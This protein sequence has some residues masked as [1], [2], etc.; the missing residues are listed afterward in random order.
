MVT[1]PTSISDPIAEVAAKAHLS[2]LK[3][4]SEK[5]LWVGAFLGGP[6]VAGYMIARNFSALG[7]PARATN[8]WRVVLPLTVILFAGIAMIPEDVNIPNFVFSMSYA[9]LSVHFLKKYQGHQLALHKEAGGVNYSWWMVV[10]IS[11]LGA[12]VIGLAFALL[13]LSAD[14]LSDPGVVNELWD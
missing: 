5:N 6:L 14:L 10:G 4:F 12:L 9:L 11:L 13:F 1:E 2:S 7:E 3:F 8:T